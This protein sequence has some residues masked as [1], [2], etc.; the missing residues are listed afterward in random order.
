V[1]ILWSNYSKLQQK[2][3]EEFRHPIQV[4]DI[5]F[6]IN[7]QTTIPNSGAARTKLGAGGTAFNG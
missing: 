7:G 2:A 1:P 6:I 3:S 5:A 4:R